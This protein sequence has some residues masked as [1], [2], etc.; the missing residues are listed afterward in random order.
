M[1]EKTVVELSAILRRGEWSPTRSELFKMP[2][3]NPTAVD[4]TLEVLCLAGVIRR[5][6]PNDLGETKYQ[7]IDACLPDEEYLRTNAHKSY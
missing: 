5:S 1:H 6:Q 3:W 7:W 2:G 4:I